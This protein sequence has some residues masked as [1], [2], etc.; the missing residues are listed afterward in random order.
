[1]LKK[2]ADILTI[3]YFIFSG[4]TLFVKPLVSDH[5]FAFISIGIGTLFLT[6]TA[7]EMYAKG[8]LPPVN[9]PQQ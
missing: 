9:P 6:A 1:M 2:I 3:L 8:E 5:T 7:L 4:E